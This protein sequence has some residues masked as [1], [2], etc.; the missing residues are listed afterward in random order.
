MLVSQIMLEEVIRDA[1]VKF[2]IECREQI[3]DY[4]CVGMNVDLLA[5]EQNTAFFIKHSIQSNCPKGPA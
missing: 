3:L 1:S 5:H 4:S 2:H